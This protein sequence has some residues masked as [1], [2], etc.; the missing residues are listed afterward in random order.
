MQRKGDKRPTVI[1]RR[2]T[3]ARRGLHSPGT[4]H[5]HT[6]LADYH[7]VFEHASVKLDVDAWPASHV[8]SVGEEG[9][10]R[11]VQVARPDMRRQPRGM[12]M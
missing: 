8:R 7:H 3:L 5:L 4:I 12:E 9:V 1:L 6:S 2:V 11:H 10:P